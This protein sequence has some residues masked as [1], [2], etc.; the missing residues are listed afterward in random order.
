MARDQVA[1]IRLLLRQFDNTDNQVAGVK[2]EYSG[3]I[4]P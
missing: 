2:K 3:N 4:C 1:W